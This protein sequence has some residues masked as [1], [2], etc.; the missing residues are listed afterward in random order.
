MSSPEA[1]ELNFTPPEYTWKQIH[2]AIPA[3]CY[4]R[5]TLLSVSYV[6]RDFFFVACLAAIAIFLIPLIESP[7]LNKLA[8]ISYSFLQGL[9]FT[10][11][12][13][14]AHECGH[15]ALS[16]YKWVNNALGMWMHSFLLVPYHS[17][18]ITHSTHHKTTNNIEADIAFVPDIQEDW[19][20]KRDSRGAF[21]RAL[22]LVEDVPIA[23]LLELIGHQL[24]AFPTYILINNFALPRMAV[25][26]WWTRSH[27]YFGGDGP[28]F[29][30]SHK[31]D[32]I[33]SDIGIATS[34]ALIWTAVQ[35]L[36]AWE[37]MKLYGFPYLWTNHWIL[38][39]TFLQHTD[40][41]LPYYRPA[42]W[43]FLR[44]AASAID[45]DFGWIGRFLFHGAIETHV[46][47]HHVS[48][49][50]FYHAPEASAA[51]RKVMGVH[52]ASD[53]ETPYLWAFWKIRHAC[54]F[55]VEKDEG[56]QIYFFD[57]TRLEEKFGKVE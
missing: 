5:D 8:W 45:R 32:I 4:E 28:N 40:I 13:E 43:T 47:H 36:G 52:Y 38:T 39:I 42:S 20:A 9:V 1:Q 41:T 46:L 27:F 53:F 55:V 17:W 34:A 37:V 2:D 29:K 6:L 26:P 19:Q 35:Y 56:S 3:H 49:I 50:P 48:R 23:V 22:E 12:W 51:L 15:G 14:L 21:L 18:R 16:D 25:F 30:P 57:R 54:R 31:K 44:G 33:M 24:I 10:G 11:L 7:L